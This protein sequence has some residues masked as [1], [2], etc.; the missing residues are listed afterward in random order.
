MS[1][2]FTDCKAQ[3]G[4]PHPSHMVV[5]KGGP[6]HDPGDRGPQDIHKRV[7]MSLGELAR[8]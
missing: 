6:Y 1:V 4:L 2:I 5:V 8:G 7:G 3:E